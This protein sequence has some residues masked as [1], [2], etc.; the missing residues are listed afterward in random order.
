VDERLQLRLREYDAL[1]LAWLLRKLFLNGE[2]SLISLVST[3]RQSIPSFTVCERELPE[4]LVGWYPLG[5]LNDEELLRQLT[6]DEFTKWP[7]VGYQTRSGE[8]RLASVGDLIAYLANV[9]GAVHVSR[10]TSTRDQGLWDLCWGFRM[11]TPH[12]QFSGGAHA[13]LEI[14]RVARAG[15]EALRAEIEA[16]VWPTWLP[17]AA[18]GTRR[19]RDPSTF[20]WPV[21]VEEDARLR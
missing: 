19:V 9:E 3:N 4:K 12:G 10:P 16:E 5:A 11:L 6:T 2:R 18:R 17:E 20:G 1:S 8:S 15:L 7:A 21:G 14:A 13:L